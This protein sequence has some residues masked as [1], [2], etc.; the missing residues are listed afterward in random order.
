M[1]FKIFNTVNS[2]IIARFLLL[3]KMRQSCK[4]NNLNLY[5]EILFMN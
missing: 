1:R 4:R 3:Q 2:E 5:F